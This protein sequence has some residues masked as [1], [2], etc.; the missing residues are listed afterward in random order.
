[1]LKA[2]RSPDGFVSRR[3]L[4][5]AEYRDYFFCMGNVRKE[6]AEDFGRAVTQKNGT[7]L[8]IASGHGLFAFELSKALPKAMI[9]GTG[10]EADRRTFI[11]TKSLFR[12][13]GFSCLPHIDAASVEGIRYLLS[14]VTSLPFRDG[15]FDGAANFLGLEDVRM[16]R[17][18]RGVRE[19]IREASRVAKRGG[20]VQFAVQVFGDSPSDILSREITEFIGHGAVFLGP[21]VYQAMIEDAG[22]E[23]VSQRRHSTKALLTARQAMEELRYACE[24]TSKTYK[25]Y[26]VTTRSFDEVWAA[27]GS[28][29]ETHGY[30]L[31][32]DILAIFSRKL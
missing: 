3:F 27:F 25:R 14:D 9:L 18:D 19:A 32:T 22:L 24:E 20:I 15:V 13:R 6:V 1:M 10:L 5:D 11:Q 23:V 12:E 2:M 7:V 30:A 8:D 29:I 31:Y 17:Q 16:T 4:T 26:N 28:R 21:A